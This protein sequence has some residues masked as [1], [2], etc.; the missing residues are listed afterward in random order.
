[1]RSP[2]KLQSVGRPRASKDSATNMLAQFEEVGLGNTT[3][4]LNLITNVVNAQ[5]SSVSS[6]RR[7]STV[8]VVVVADVAVNDVA[9]FDVVLEKLDVVRVLVSVF[10]MS[11]VLA[12]SNPTTSRDSAASLLRFATAISSSDSSTR[13]AVLLTASLDEL[14]TTASMTVLY[15][16]PAYSTVQTMFTVRVSLLNLL[17]AEKL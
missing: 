11:T 12:I 7:G 2:L 6:S 15:I 10:E 3:P 14:L 8:V 17:L 5:V 1:V 13:K 4:A 9:V 16:S